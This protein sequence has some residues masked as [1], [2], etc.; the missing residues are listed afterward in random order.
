MKAGKRIFSFVLACLMIF[1][2]APQV[3]AETF[4]VNSANDW[5]N[6][7][8]TASNNSDSSNT[9]NVTND[10]DMQG[11]T[12]YAENDKTYIVN[13]NGDHII[14]HVGIVNNNDNAN[15]NVIIN[16]DIVGSKDVALTV[17][18]GNVTVNGIVSTVHME[19]AIT[20]LDASANA[21]VTVNGDVGSAVAGG[22]KNPD[23]YAVTAGTGAKVTIAGDIFSAENGVSVIL[24]AS[25]TVQQDI[26]T[27][28]T[29]MKVSDNATLI[30][31]HNVEGGTAH[32]TDS[33][34]TVGGDFTS[35]GNVYI[36]G[37]SLTMEEGSMLEA[38]QIHILGDSEV[39]VGYIDANRVTVGT[40]GGE[41]DT[42]TLSSDTIT[43]SSSNSK[44][45][46]GGKATVEVAGN[47]DNVVAK[48]N[49]KVTVSGTADSITKT[50]KAQVSVKG[51]TPST[52]PYTP[53]PDDPVCSEPDIDYQKKYPSMQGTLQPTKDIIT[54][55]KEFDDDK[56]NNDMKKHLNSI[57]T[58]RMDL[59]RDIDKLNT[60]G[61]AII[62]QTILT[63][64]MDKHNIGRSLKSDSLDESLYHPD[65]I[66]EFK[67]HVTVRKHKQRYYEG[68]YETLDI[69]QSI[70]YMYQD[71]LADSLKNASDVIA[72]NSS[73][74]YDEQTLLLA[75]SVAQ[76]MIGFTSGPCTGLSP[77]SYDFTEVIS[78]V[79]EIANL[80][81]ER[82]EQFKDT[83]DKMLIAFSTA[84]DLTDTSTKTLTIV[85]AI[86]T[87]AEFLKFWATDYSC[88]IEVLDN[89][90]KEQPMNV[91][92]FYAAVDLR[93]KY[94]HK[95][96]AIIEEM[97]NK[98][99]NFGIEQAL[100]LIPGFKKTK[101]VLT[102][103]ANT[104][105]A[106][107]YRVLVEGVSSSMVL[108]EAHDAYV[109]AIEKVKAGDH[110]EE[111]MNMVYMTFSMYKNTMLT[112]CDALIANGDGSQAAKYRNKKAHLERLQVGQLLV[113][114]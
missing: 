78:K 62:A 27:D 43:N 109:S 16:S 9:F 56:A 68:E 87:N 55:C 86:L 50:D 1:S 101:A 94:E 12:L 49:A 77:T 95:I 91:E 36:N 90:L 29:S 93:Y 13:N 48:Q 14:Q 10:I 75:S 97:V 65:T 106:D 57:D 84:A 30:V 67:K 19:D 25:V 24:D 41:G 38:D 108:S 35:E 99:M 39:D 33:D 60:V 85:Q 88:Q 7:W 54:L 73:N 96:Q 15:S 81:Q 53:F 2:A 47:V 61:N 110:S 44:L 3:F 72:A 23:N 34:V 45:E 26:E 32:I 100:G 8:N 17:I 59:V 20:A 107:K 89:L 104:N 80:S 52:P 21:K 4:Q 83:L 113:G 40:T 98:A 42:S 71:Q 28:G 63:I 51:S 79:P 22:S 103:A 66:A 102:I 5:V 64:D 70:A 6:D 18:E 69:D 74:S 58:L 114:T 11:H 82:Q 112:M 111:A 105:A 31:G 46:A 37:S 76:S 92:M